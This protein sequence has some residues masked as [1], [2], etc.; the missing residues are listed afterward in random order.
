[1]SDSCFY[2]SCLQC[3]L[4]TSLFL[5]QIYFCLVNFLIYHDST[6]FNHTSLTM[7]SRQIL[8]DSTN[9]MDLGDSDALED[10][11]TQNSPT[12]PNCF[13][14]TKLGVLF[15]HF[16]YKKNHRKVQCR[17]CDLFIISNQNARLY[18]HAETC[19]KISEEDKAVIFQS[20]TDRTKL[21]KEQQLNES[22]AK[23]WTRCLIRTGWHRGRGCEEILW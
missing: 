10:S 14:N 8:F 23:L 6:K 5:C 20:S 9:I 22:H 1:M 4:C 13:R 19:R 18:R 3:T 11:S 16:G 15:T 7:H 17:K 21:N 12:S 2:V